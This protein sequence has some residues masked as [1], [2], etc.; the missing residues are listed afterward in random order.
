MT[1][2]AITQMESNTGGIAFQMEE[3]RGRV[4]FLDSLGKIICSGGEVECFLFSSP[5]HL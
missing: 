1:L 5:V 4:M 2:N 3:V